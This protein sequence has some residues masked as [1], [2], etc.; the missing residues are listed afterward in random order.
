[1]PTRTH[2][3]DITDHK[4]GALGVSVSRSGQLM[5][6]HSGWAGGIKFW[7]PH[8]RKLLLSI[9]SGGNIGLDGQTPDGRLFAYNI[10][11][12]RLQLWGTESSP[13]L[14]LLVREP[15]RGPLGEYRR[16]S[17]HR[18]GRL[19]AVG[20]THGVSLFDLDRGLD[21]G[22][23]DIGD[24][25]TAQFDPA[26]GDLLTLGN[27]GLIRWPVRSERGDPARLR[28][29]PPK[30]LLATRAHDNE[31]RISNDGRTI[32]IAQYSR[33]LVLHADQPDRPVILGPTV[34]VRQQITISPD[35]RWV[36]TGSHGGGG[37]VLVWEART[38]RLVKRQRVG[39][40]CLAQFT[41]DGTRLLAGTKTLCRFWGVGD[42]KEQE[43][44]FTKCGFEHPMPTFSPDGRML[45]W[46]SGEGALRLLDT[47]TGRVL[48][49]LESP[50]EGRCT[51]TT[52]SPKGR[53]L[54]TRNLDSQ[55]IYVWDLHELRRLLKSLDLDWDA[56][57]DPSAEV[58]ADGVPLPRLEVEVDAGSLKSLKQRQAAIQRNYE[59]WRLVT[60]PAAKRDPARALELIQQALH[61]DPDNRALQNT[62][63]VVQYR[64]KQYAA[65][66]VSLEKSLAAG[67]GQYDAFD[68]FFLAMCRA[69][70]GDRDKAK[71]CFDRAV[72][73]TE[74]Q[75]GLP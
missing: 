1:V 30:R 2:F 34:D 70:L 28:L 27:L 36:A 48:A 49:R 4:G 72:K 47:T 23:L 73:W 60:G 58:R 12:T 43:P 55:V 13:I 50:D 45:A 75:K 56:P 61:D 65:A 40:Y 63:G 57:S 33:V 46:D 17:V 68:L 29:G 31:F 41:P 7:H 18:D 67:K 3:H 54:I 44:E 16:S 6:T 9:P 71:D 10:V 21:V 69:K 51:Y 53:F 62:L 5:S 64:N 24:N 59:A 26:T 66:I 52:F 37:D 25:V 32:A 19:L 38:A 22:H 8:S 15:G 14:R 42:W 35:G 20:T 11:G 39:G 74:A